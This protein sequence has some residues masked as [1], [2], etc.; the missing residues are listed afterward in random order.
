MYSHYSCLL[1]SAFISCYISHCH[2][3]DL[4]DEF[5]HT[6]Q[7]YETLGLSRIE[8]IETFSARMSLL[9][10]NLKKK[11]YDPLEHRKMDFEA[12]Y[13]DFKLQHLELQAC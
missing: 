6:A 4:I 1:M 7:V 11:P 10:S 8:G 5:L 9:V 13:Q 12:D 2:R 3:V